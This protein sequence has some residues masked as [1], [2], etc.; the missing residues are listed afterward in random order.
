MISIL[1]LYQEFRKVQ[2]AIHFSPTCCQNFSALSLCTYCREPLWNQLGCLWDGAAPEKTDRWTLLPSLFSLLP[3]LPPSV[4]SFPLTGERKSPFPMTF[5][6]RTRTS[7]PIYR[8]SSW[9]N[10][11]KPSCWWVCLSHC[12]SFQLEGSIFIKSFFLSYRSCCSS[13]HIAEYPFNYLFEVPFRHR[14]LVKKPN[15]VFLFT[16]SFFL[17]LHQ[18]P[19]E[20]NRLFSFLH[21]LLSFSL[22]LLHLPFLYLHHRLT[23]FLQFSLLFQPFLTC[24]FF[25]FLL[26]IFG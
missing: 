18:L 12:F 7:A 6:F 11:L 25:H 23:F 20:F 22:F 8:F 4:V 24:F 13:I 9:S 15:I 19:I 21:E 14:A 16:L 3:I 2:F 17:F 5:S 1:S 26:V 10:S